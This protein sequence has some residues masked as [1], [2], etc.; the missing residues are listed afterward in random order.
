MNN[1]GNYLLFYYT[2]YYI[3][4]CNILGEYVVSK[5]YFRD[6]S[7]MDTAINYNDHKI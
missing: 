1:F 5:V 3:I 6:S 7:L 4:V 2:F